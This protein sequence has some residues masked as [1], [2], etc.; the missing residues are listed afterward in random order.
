[1]T[2]SNTDTPTISPALTYPRVF[3]TSHKTLQKIRLTEQNNVGMS[4]S[5]FSFAQQVYDWQGDSWMLDGS[6]PPLKIADAEAWIAFLGSLRGRGGTFLASDTARKTA[7][8]NISG[9]SPTVDVFWWRNLQRSG[10]LSLNGLAASRSGVLKA[11][12]YIEIEKNYLRD[13]I[14]LN[15]LMTNWTRVGGA[16]VTAGTGGWARLTLPSKAGDGLDGI[17]IDLNPINMVSGLRFMMYVRAVTSSAPIE[18]VIEDLPSTGVS[19]S[20]TPTVLTS[21]AVY[22]LTG[23]LAPTSSN[24]VRVYIRSP[25]TGAQAARTIEIYAACFSI[26][27]I[28]CSLHKC[29]VDLNS[30]GSGFGEVDIFPRLRTQPGPLEPVYFSNYNGLFRLTGNKTQWDI[31]Q[32]KIYGISFSAQEAL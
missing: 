32:A 22:T 5:P 4:A 6:L 29:L 11:G 14:V 25:Y 13:A 2:I 27:R 19:L 7:Q 21:D 24:R 12:D 31:D 17:Y 15:T 20:T 8:G 30:D 23:T 28:D 3:P 10:V 16:T 26:P 18:V 1:M 9:C